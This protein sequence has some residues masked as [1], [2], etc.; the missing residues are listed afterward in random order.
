[1]SDKYDLSRRK[2]LLGL[3]TIGVAS[4]GAGVG[5]SAYFSDKESFENSELNAGELNLIVDYHTYVNQGHATD[6]TRST[7][8]SGPIDGEPVS[9]EYDINDLKPG[10]SGKLKFCPK[11]VGNPAWVWVGSDG[12][13][14]YENGRTDPEQDVDETTGGNH[15]GSNNGKGHGEL[16]EA[17]EITDIYYCDKDGNRKENMDII[18]EISDDYTLAELSDALQ[19]GIPLD[20]GSGHDI[21]PYHPG[22]EKTCLC[23][24]WKVPKSVGNEI[25]T[26]GVTFDIEFAAIQKRH[27]EDNQQ[28]PFN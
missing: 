10:D 21:D 28:N 1:M 23:I 22:K 5:T 2:A 27:N 20:G 25:Q 9:H 19:E 4:A 15:D 24:E 13:V 17:I 8:G 11:V 16:S 12:V 14:D 18:L 6:Y 3:G 7:T 26:D